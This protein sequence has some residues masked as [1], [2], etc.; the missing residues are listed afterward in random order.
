MRSLADFDRMAEVLQYLSKHR[1]CGG[2]KRQADLAKDQ[3]VG[4]GVFLKAEPTSVERKR[5]IGGGLELDC[6]EN[7]FCFSNVF[8]AM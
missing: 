2:V 6:G 3:R 5:R 8:K 7:E 4:H 1:C